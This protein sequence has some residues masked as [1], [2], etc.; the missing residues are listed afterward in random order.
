MSEPLTCWVLSDG[1]RGIENQALGLAEAMS[2]HFTAEHPELDIQSHYMSRKGLLARLPAGLQRLLGR[3]SGLPQD[4]PQ[5]AIGCGRQAIAP[6]LDLR[7]KGVF[8]VYVQDPRMSPDRFDVV[9][10]PEHDA[11]SGDNV[12]SIIGSTNRITPQRLAQDQDMI[13]PNGD[14]TA[15]FLIGGKSKTH[16]YPQATIH[17]HAELITD[18]LASGWEIYLTSSRRTP[19]P[20]YKY[21]S[22][23]D[24]EFENFHFYTGR[25]PNPY[26]AYLHHADMIFVTEDSTNMLTEACTTGKP[27][28]R[29]PMPGQPGKFQ[30]LYNALEARCRVRSAIGTDLTPQTYA[31]LNETKRAAAFVWDKFHKTV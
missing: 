16:D 13:S 28:F 10:A 11:L 14:R 9:I 21:F 6:L 26:F 4:L 15:V 12:L 31:P 29:L 3:N 22:L 25:G 5:I 2:G 20:A 7:A 23:F 30:M 1:R 27:V 8:T 17:A 18:L 19:V 24:D